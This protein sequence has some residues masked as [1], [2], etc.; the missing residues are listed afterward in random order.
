MRD[1]LQEYR[2]PLVRVSVVAVIGPD[3]KQVYT[4]F[5]PVTSVTLIPAFWGRQEDEVQKMALSPNRFLKQKGTA[6]GAHST[7]SQSSHLIVA[8]RL[9]SNTAHILAAYFDKRILSNEWWTLI[10]NDDLKTNDGQ[11]IDLEKISKVWTLWINS[12]PGIL[13]YLANREETEGSWIQIKKESIKRMPI[14]DVRKLSSYQVNLMVALF[15]RLKDK[16][17]GRF[18]IQFKEASDMV[19]SRT[20]LDVELIKIITG[21]DINRQNLAPLYSV[22][23]SEVRFS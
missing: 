17:F 2:F 14:L 6:S 19:N 4:N 15:D 11:V 13:I 9:R 10:P 23:A 7:L 12:T 22:L 8:Q 16:S 1:K 20:E 21:K 3:A 18:G 5:D